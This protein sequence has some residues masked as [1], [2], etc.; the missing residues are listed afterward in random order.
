MLQQE[1]ANAHDLG[2]KLRE[3]EAESE[4]AKDQLGKQISELEEALKK[5]Q[6]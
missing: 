3:S 1:K 5:A 4:R 2:M 6:V